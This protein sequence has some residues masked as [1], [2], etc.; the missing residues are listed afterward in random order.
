MYTLSRRNAEDVC[1]GLCG[2]GIAAGCYHT[3]RLP[4]D[5]TKTH[6]QWLE[7]S[8]QVRDKDKLA[9][10]NGSNISWLSNDMKKQA[11]WRQCQFGRLSV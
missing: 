9:V 5:K 8:V 1:A 6:R 10:W 11:F 4:Q 7:G 3:D 2:A